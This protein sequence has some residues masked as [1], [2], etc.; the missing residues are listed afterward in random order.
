MG[1]YTR[2]HEGDNRTYSDILK[3]PRYTATRP[4]PTAKEVYIHSKRGLGASEVCTDL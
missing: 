2:T 4:I 1:I 3:R